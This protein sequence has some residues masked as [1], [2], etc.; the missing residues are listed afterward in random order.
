MNGQNIPNLKT[1]AV[2]ALLWA[3]TL[4]TLAAVAAFS[5]TS[6]AEVAGLGLA[7]GLSLSGALAIAKLVFVDL[8]ET[9][10]NGRIEE[11]VVSL[12]T[13]SDSRSAAKAA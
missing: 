10:A 6:T 11:I 1:V 3:S 5:A 8:A 13:K 12:S 4:A 9:R 7:S 2:A